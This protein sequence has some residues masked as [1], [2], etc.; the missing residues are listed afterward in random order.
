MKSETHKIVFT[1]KEPDEFYRLQKAL[2]L[3]KAD[4]NEFFDCFEYATFELE[5][6]SALRVVSGRIVGQSEL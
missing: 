6:D 4:I 5:I 1:S 2:G 3:S